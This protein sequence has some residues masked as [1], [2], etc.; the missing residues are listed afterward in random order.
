MCSKKYSLVLAIIQA[1]LT[2]TR[3]PGKILEK[4]EGKTILEHCIERVKKATLVDRVV[5]ATPH[6][7]PI[8]LDVPLFIGDE[9]DVL[10][11]FYDCAE[12]YDPD[13]I[14]RI[15]ADCPFIDPCAIDIAI[16]YYLHH[17]HKYVCFAPVDGLDVEVFGRYLLNEAHVNAIEPYDREHVTPYMRRATKLSVDTAEDLTKVRG[18]Y[19]LFK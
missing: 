13:I 8:M 14:V 10:K 9:Q 19:G 16:S 15:T 17:P 1:R 12:L 7:I 6:D 5:V 18:E 4:I 2:S 11:R 3:L